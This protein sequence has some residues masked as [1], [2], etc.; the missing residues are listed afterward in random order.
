MST[1]DQSEYLRKKMAERRIRSA[2]GPEPTFMKSGFQRWAENER[3]TRMGGVEKEPMEA[4]REGGRNILPELKKLGRQ[5]F[6]KYYEYEGGAHEA[7]SDEESSSSESDMEGGRVDYLKR[8]IGSG[9]SGNGYSLYQPGKSVNVTALSKRASQMAT[10]KGLSECPPSHP[11]DDGLLCRQPLKM[12]DGQVTG[13][14]VIPKKITKKGAGKEISQYLGQWYV[15]ETDANGKIIKALSGPHKSE[16]EARRG[17]EKK[18]RKNKAGKKHSNT[19]EEK[20]S[21]DED[22]ATEA[23]ANLGKYGKGRKSGFHSE[24]MPSMASIKTAVGKIAQRGSGFKEGVNESKKAFNALGD[25]A[26]HGHD[27]YTHA[28][29]GNVLGMLDD[30]KKIYTSGV[31]LGDHAQKAAHEFKTGGK[32]KSSARGEL[33]KRIMKEKGLSLPQASKYVKEHNLYKG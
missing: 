29:S 32:K 15:W 5:M 25:V 10:G 8:E 28:Q 7:G 24:I 17:V 27:A 21:D 22:E 19:K 2:L 16:D 3:P 6:E 33:V 11:I 12:K 9:Y 26:I 23:L 31:E 18:T 13:G 20:H 4:T 1:G 30:S 14:E